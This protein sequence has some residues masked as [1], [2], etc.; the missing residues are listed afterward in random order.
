MN[1]LL[2]AITGVSLLLTAIA[3]SLAWRV[4]RDARRQSDSRVSALSKEIYGDDDSAEAPIAPSMP[5]SRYGVI[6]IGAA[7]TV[8]VA[9]FMWGGP[10]SW[11]DPSRVAQVTNQKNPS[12]NLGSPAHKP[13]DTSLEL[14][15]LEHERD[16]NRLVVRGLVRNP[17]TGAARDGLTAVVLAYSRTGDL[18][19]S[20]RASVLAAKLAPGVTTPFVVDVAGADAIDR[21]RVSFQTGTR[22][23]THVDRRPRGDIAKEVDP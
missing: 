22:V 2:L 18:L 21:F 16:G 20:G 8:A 7:V 3:W 14:L 10:Y 11:G 23:V 4:T 19:A 1:A 17:A 13:S 5:A 6:A 9:V 12:H 15:T